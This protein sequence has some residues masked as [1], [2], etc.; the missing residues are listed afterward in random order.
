MVHQQQEFH[1]QMPR[2]INIQNARNIISID[3]MNITEHLIEDV[4]LK[5]TLFP[6]Y[7]QAANLN[8]FRIFI[9]SFAPLEVSRNRKQINGNKAS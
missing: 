9:F 5:P 7:S 4:N 2:K 1:L 8:V 3:E 6:S